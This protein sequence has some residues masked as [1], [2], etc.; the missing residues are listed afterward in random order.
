MREL[1]G[2]IDIGSF[3]LSYLIETCR[4]EMRSIYIS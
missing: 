1:V 4:A 2:D 3:Y